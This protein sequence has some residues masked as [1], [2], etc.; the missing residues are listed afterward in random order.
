MCDKEIIE[1]MLILLKEGFSM[2]EVGRKLGVSNTCVRYNTNSGLRESERTHA[3]NRARSTEAINKRLLNEY[4]IT[5]DEWKTMRSK[6]NGKCA[7][8][9]AVLSEKPSRGTHVDH[10]HE[11][12]IVRGIL[13]AQ[14][15]H[16]IGHFKNNPDF[17][18]NAA[19]YLLD[20]KA[21]IKAIG[22]DTNYS[23]IQNTG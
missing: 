3:R 12:G 13:C 15:N 20:K 9:S 18:I 14:C 7:I 2:R 11:T 19:K 4:G 23:D 22:V 1:K 17:C 8:C 6:Q 16:G 10:S 21:C 5:L